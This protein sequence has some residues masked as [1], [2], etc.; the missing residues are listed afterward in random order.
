VT[1]LKIEEIEKFIVWY[2]PA[3]I[4]VWLIT[5][6]SIPISQAYLADTDRSSLH[7]LLPAVVSITSY[8]D[9]LV[10]AIWLA[11]MTS[12]DGA[13][14]NLWFLFGV[15]SGLFGVMIYLLLDKKAKA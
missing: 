10:C 8:L 7:L 11:S 9:N 14:R 1:P 3:A 4:L 12:R 6:L 5:S 13:R 15:V 2:V